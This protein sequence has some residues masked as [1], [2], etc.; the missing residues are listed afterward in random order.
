VAKHPHVQARV[1]DEVSALGDRPITAAD[2]LHLA[3]AE[4][5]V[6]EALRLYPPTWSLFPREAISDVEV[7][8]YVLPRGSWVSILPWVLHRAPRW[9]PEPERF[10]PDRFAPGRVE[11]IPKYAYLPFGAGSHA[12]IGSAFATMEMVLVLTTIVRQF[13]LALAPG[14]AEAEPEPLVA[15]R[16]KGEVRLVVHSRQAL[17][18]ERV[19]RGTTV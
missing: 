16:P 14:Q 7:G 2:L 3:Y 19:A 15:L 18:A 10:D 5:V 13:R 11:Q 6:K 9:F 17:E 12:C 8:G 4:Q 1:G